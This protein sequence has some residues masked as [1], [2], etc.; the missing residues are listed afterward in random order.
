M[1]AKDLKQLRTKAIKDLEDLIRTKKQELLLSYAKIKAGKEKNT[2]LVRKISRDI[3][4]L[5]TIVKEKE[6]LER[7]KKI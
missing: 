4:Q 1:K 3:A 5:S 2:S 7:S 6:I